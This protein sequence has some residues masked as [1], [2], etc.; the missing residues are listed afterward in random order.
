MALLQLGKLELVVTTPGLVGERPFAKYCSSPD[1]RNQS[2]ILNINVSVSVDS[3]PEKMCTLV[4][5]R[6]RPS[7]VGS[8]VTS[9]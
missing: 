4:L 9:L 3:S 6:S 7:A 1:G 8:D 5:R 2:N